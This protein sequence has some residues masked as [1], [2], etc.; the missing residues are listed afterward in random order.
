[1][2][3]VTS[4]QTGSTRVSSLVVATVASATIAS[5]IVLGTLTGVL[6][7][8]N[9][10]IRGEEPLPRADPQAPRSGACAL[11]GTIESIRVIEVYEEAGAANSGT[12]AK[13]P[14]ETAGGGPGGAIASA[15]TSMLDTLSTTMKGNDA[16]K[17]LRKRHV[18]RVTLR[19][20]DGSFRAISLSSPPSFAVGD[21]V[22]V[23]EGR[24]VRA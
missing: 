20:D 5:L 10:A 19:M 6:P 11:C 23:V 18:Y 2:E 16:E 8:R 13:T 1:M 9:P 14:A 21:K 15:A 22:R 4:R 7:S 12:D 17:S 24:L 3:A